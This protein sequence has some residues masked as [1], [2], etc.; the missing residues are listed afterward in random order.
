MRG[1]LARSFVLYNVPMSRQAT[2]H[3]AKTRAAILQTAADLASVDG[4]DGLSIGRLATELAMSKSGLFAHFGSKED[5]QLATIEEA[6]QRYTREVITPA[7][8]AGSGIRRLYALCEA[9][10]SYLERAVFP[11]G[12]FFASAMA[13]FD[14]KPPGPVRD[15]IADCQN[16]WMNTLE[17]AARDA[18]E[19][20]ELRT[21]SDL[22]QL[23]S[24]GPAEPSG[25]GW[26]VKQPPPA[27]P[28]DPPD[29][30][31]LRHRPRNH[32][33]W[34]MPAR[35]MRPKTCRQ[36]DIRCEGEP[37][38]DFTRRSAPRQWACS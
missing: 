37:V 10:L 30:A 12:C 11:G 27:S 28:C 13:E 29:Q 6:R 7:Q 26:P 23:A 15:R 34:G 33:N 16:Q 9:F 35:S 17:R 24:F 3:G 25:R 14:G 31:R 2:S 22:R 1:R 19:R 21:G 36:A 20:S 4:L 5:L 8:A 18:Q 38:P 32:S